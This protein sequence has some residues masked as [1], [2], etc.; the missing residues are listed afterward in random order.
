MSGTKFG[1]LTHLCRKY[2]KGKKKDQCCT[3]SI[4]LDLESKTLYPDLKFHRAFIKA[5]APQNMCLNKITDVLV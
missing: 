3:G 5:N 4:I 1:D 2:C